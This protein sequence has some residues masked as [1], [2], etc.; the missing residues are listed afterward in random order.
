M[1]N[2]PTVDERSTFRPLRAMLWVGGLAGERVGLVVRVGLAD[3]VWD[4]FL[5]AL[6]LLV[7]SAL[8]P[9]RTTETWRKPAVRHN[10]EMSS[11]ENNQESAR[12]VQVLTTRT[13]DVSSGPLDLRQWSVS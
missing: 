7:V 4:S 3:M 1:G 11:S 13:I 8:W 2:A 5:V 10:K 6:E 12:R 9:Y